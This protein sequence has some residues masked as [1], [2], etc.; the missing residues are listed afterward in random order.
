MGAP[1]TPRP[2]TQS[3]LVAVI[4]ANCCGSAQA[5][6]VDDVLSAWKKHAAGINSLQYECE[7]TRTELVN[8][9]GSNDPFGPEANATKEPVALKGDVTFSIAGGKLAV[10][11]VAEFWDDDEKGPKPQTHRHV[12]DGKQNRDLYLGTR[13]PMGHINDA[14][15]PSE[16]LTHHVELAPL[17]LAYSPLTYLEKH[18]NL[19]LSKMR[20][21][22]EVMTCGDRQCLE[23]SVEAGPNKN[24]SFVLHVSATS[25]YRPLRWSTLVNGVPRHET[26]LKYDPKREAVWSL[27]EYSTS[28][29]D[30]VG[31]VSLNI[32]GVVK[33]QW[34]NEA[35]DKAVFII[36]YPE[37]TH[38]ME[39]GATFIQKAGKLQPIE[40][41][42]F[43]AIPASGDL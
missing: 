1:T 25:D 12:F 43:G 31:E 21:A 30:S 22:K 27:S 11:R 8:K 23:L 41:K 10:L 20:I 14:K 7:C 18:K 15:I 39:N 26:T 16:S 6:T 35:L 37:G 2:H 19:S 36:D 24:A 42:Q 13:I 40:Q 28:I 33:K 34:V 4:L 5:V 9:S 32:V 3:A 17:W 29:Y 38:V